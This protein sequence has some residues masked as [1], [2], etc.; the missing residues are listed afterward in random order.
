EGRRQAILGPGGWRVEDG[1]AVGGRGAEDLVSAHAREAGAAQ[2]PRRLEAGLARHRVRA[3][4]LRRRRRVERDRDLPGRDV[5]SAVAADVDEG[6]ARALARVLRA[7]G[8]LLRE[9]D[10]LHVDVDV[11]EAVVEVLDVVRGD[12]LA[13]VATA[14]RVLGRVAAGADPDLDGLDAE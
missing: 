2:H 6:P 1:R 8:T 11:D 14:R 9:H 3:G 12:V 4:R 13:G 10:L 7:A 5:V